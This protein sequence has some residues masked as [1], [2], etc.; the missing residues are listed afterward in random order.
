MVAH[1]PEKGSRP[2]QH[3]LWITHKPLGVT[4]GRFLVSCPRNPQGP[5]HIFSTAPT[6]RVAFSGTFFTPE[7]LQNRPT[8]LFHPPFTPFFLFYETWEEPEDLRDPLYWK[9]IPLAF[10]KW[11]LQGLQLTESSIWTVAV[12]LA[13]ESTG[14]RIANFSYSRF[15]GP[16]W[17]SECSVY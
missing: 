6:Q 3:W 9:Y 10:L 12:P 2:L 4:C 8:T 17:S 16:E 14:A 15:C 13:R 7:S 1:K 5:I 11:R